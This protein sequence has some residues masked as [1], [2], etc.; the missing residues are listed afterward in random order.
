M[1]KRV[2]KP[3]P[4]YFSGDIEND[5]PFSHRTVVN[6]SGA[7]ARD[8]RTTRGI[9]DIREEIS[10]IERA[11][12]SSAQQPRRRTATESIR[13]PRLVQSLPKPNIQPLLASARVV[14][15]QQPYDYESVGDVRPTIAD[16]RRQSNYHSITKQAVSDL[17]AES[18]EDSLSDASQE[19][20]REKSKKGKIKSGMNRKATDSVKKQL[21]WPHLL[22]QNSYV[23]SNLGFHDLTFPL[24][25]AGELEILCSMLPS[26]A[27]A[28]FLTRLEFLK[29]LAYEANSYP[30]KAVSEWYAAYLRRLELGH[31]KWGDSFYVPGQQILAKYTP[32]SDLKKKDFGKEGKSMVYFCGAFN[33][34]NCDKKSPHEGQIRGRAVKMEHI[35]AN[36][37]QKNKVK[38]FHAEGTSECSYYKD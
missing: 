15:D 16:L 32:K 3:N 24:F 29:T 18:D 37:W 19:Q 2:R 7:R 25:V 1:D 20:L 38:K 30:L 27:S 9:D 31:G 26:N 5:T 35:C 36:C 11:I 13:P 17:W 22:L 12:A 6:Q 10:S 34:G 8:P 14:R 28:E 23:T 21:L 4:R 33:K